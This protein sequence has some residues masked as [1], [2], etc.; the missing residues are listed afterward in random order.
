MTNTHPET[1]IRYGCLYLNSI[2][3]EIANDLWMEGD[4]LSYKA[5][6]E[7]LRAEV[8]RDAENVEDEVRI[9]IA[10]SD[11]SLVGNEAWFERRCDDAWNALGYDC[12][13]DYVETRIEREAEYI[14]I[15]EPN[16]AGNYEGVRYE[17]SHLGGAPLLWILHSPVISKARLCSPCVPNCG[18][19]HALDDDGYECYGIPD[20]WRDE[21]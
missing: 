21:E 15:D 9:A 16:I 18:D 8:E 10:E 2:N 5:A 7:E 13:E 17:I 1:G 12:R 3:P 6:L 14:Q 20:D 11:P 4:D 19:L